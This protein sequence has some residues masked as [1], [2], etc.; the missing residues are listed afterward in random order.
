[1]PAKI[2]EAALIDAGIDDL[3]LPIR[4]QLLRD[5]ELATD[6]GTCKHAGIVSWLVDH[7]KVSLSRQP[8]KTLYLEVFQ[9]DNQWNEPAATQRSWT[10]FPDEY[11]DPRYVRQETIHKNV[12]LHKERCCRYRYCIPIV[13]LSIVLYLLCVFV[14]G[15]AYDRYYGRSSSDASLYNIV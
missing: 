14:L 5:P 8:E 10:T 2:E 11:D 9:D 4:L 13:A 12:A 15:L 7:S 3:Q 1:M 6:A